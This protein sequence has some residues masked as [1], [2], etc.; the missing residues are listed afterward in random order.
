MGR[1]G[2]GLLVALGA[3]L[4]G[5]RQG[6]E[7]KMRG[8]M[9]TVT[10]PFVDTGPLYSMRVARGDSAS[11]YKIALV[12]V[13][14]LLLNQDMSGMYSMGE[15]PVSLFREK[16]DR[17]AANPCYAAVVVRINS[18]GGGVTASDIMWQDLQSFRQRTGRPVVACVLDCAAG[19]G[20]Y[21]ATASDAIVAHP[22]SVVGGI[23]VILNLY[24]LTDAMQYFNVIGTPLKAGPN[25]DMGSPIEPSEEAR[26]L[27]Q[28]MADEFQARFIQVVNETRPQHEADPAVHFDGRVFTARQALDIGLVDALGYVDECIAMA[29]EM[30]GCPGAPVEML[31]RCA[32]RA[33]TPYAVTPNQPQQ[34]AMVPMSIPGLDRSRLPTFLYM[35]Q[36]EP[37]QERLGGR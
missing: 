24:N 37:T 9:S 1:R 32:D 33:R 20:Y 2:W 36:P 15:N 34:L 11:E 16:L 5:C 23:G 31:H 18:P 4:C 29:R 25:I 35:W 8:Q 19:G 17:I 6:M 27:L 3:L 7:V 28:Q 12:D 30:S 13:D 10:P 26:E 22:T 14:G 21:L